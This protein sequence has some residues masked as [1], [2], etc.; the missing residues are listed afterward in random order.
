M[1]SAGRRKI[2]LL[3]ERINPK[4]V[5]KVNVMKILP[6][7]SLLRLNPKIPSPKRIAMDV[8]MTIKRNIVSMEKTKVRKYS[9]FAIYPPKIPKMTRKITNPGRRSGCEAVGIII[10]L[11]NETTNIALGTPAITT[12]KPFCQFSNLLETELLSFILILL[13][14]D[15][16]LCFL[17]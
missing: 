6:M 4:I 5:V 3:I 16:F 9:F 17:S 8:I 2:V 12:R 7:G 13:S 10:E 14:K 11:I 15:L 1:K